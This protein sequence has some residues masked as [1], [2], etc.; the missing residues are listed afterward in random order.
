MCQVAILIINYNTYEKTFECVSS[1]REKTHIPYKIYLLDNGSSND[2][3][4]QLEKEFQDSED[5][6][7]IFSKE[8]T[9]YARGN[10]LLLQK[11]YSDGFKYAVVMNNDIICLNDAIDVM[12]RT[13]ETN[14]EY[15]MVGPRMVGLDKNIQLSAKEERPSFHKYFIRETWFE[16]FETRKKNQWKVWCLECIENSQVYWLSGAIFAVRLSEF[17]R[18]D[19]FDKY[20]FLYFEEFIL[21]EKAMKHGLKMAYVPSAEVLHYHGASCGSGFNFKTRCE[22]WRS[23]LYFLRKYFKWNYL[24]ISLIYIVRVVETYIFARKEKSALKYTMKYLRYGVRQ[25]RKER[26]GE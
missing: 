21:S 14:L 26:I 3:S 15:F 25:I 7:L 11:A 24:K 6:Q 22:N 17:Q 1:I 20:T 10:N 8:N 23:E 4:K 5:V 18:I 13:L 19:Y 12:I 2:S 9:G 16:R